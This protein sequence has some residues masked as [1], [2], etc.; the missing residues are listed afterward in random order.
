MPFVMTPDR[1]RCAV[2]ADAGTKMCI[3]SG[4]E[5][6]FVTALF[7]SASISLR[8]EIEIRP[9]YRDKPIVAKAPENP[10]VMISAGYLNMVL[11]RKNL[12]DFDR[13]TELVEYLVRMIAFINKYKPLA[14]A[15]FLWSDFDQIP[16]E[17][18]LYR[19]PSDHDLLR[20][21]IDPS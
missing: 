18:R 21:S 7:E 9:K 8:L 19:M 11:R 4:P 15:P 6:E 10:C 14:N 12:L 1:R 16:L 13:N 17:S 20:L 2:D 3:N 5:M